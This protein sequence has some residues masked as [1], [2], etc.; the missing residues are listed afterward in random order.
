MFKALW[1]NNTADN[2]CENVIHSSLNL[3]ANGVENYYNQHQNDTFINE[4]IP[5]TKCWSK[6]N[7]TLTNENTKYHYGK[8]FIQ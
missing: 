1:S 3:W 6:N 5:H 2:L 4:I 8:N 7:L